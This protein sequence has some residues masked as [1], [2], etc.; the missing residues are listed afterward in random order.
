MRRRQ[1][2]QQQRRRHEQI[3]R[4]IIQHPGTMLRECGKVLSATIIII[5][6]SI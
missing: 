6:S 2:Q 1:Q 4:C 3:A 5:S